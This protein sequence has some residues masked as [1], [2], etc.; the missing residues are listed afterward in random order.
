MEELRDI[1]RLSG[2]CLQIQEEIEYQEKRSKEL[3][4]NLQ[5]KVLAHVIYKGEP[6]QIAVDKE[7]VLNCLKSQIEVSWGELA[8][9][10]AELI[11]CLEDLKNKKD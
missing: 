11:F 9:K 1:N 8:S 4:E 6:I 10:R 2:F 5:D 7:D 3:E